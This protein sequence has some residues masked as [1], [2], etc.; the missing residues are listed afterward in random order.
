MGLTSLGPVH[1]YSMCTFLCVTVDT[2]NMNNNHGAIDEA[3]SKLSYVVIE[4]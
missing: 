3:A 2:Y 4:A 1:L